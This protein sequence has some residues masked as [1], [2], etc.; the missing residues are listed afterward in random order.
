MVVSGKVSQLNNRNE[1]D[2]GNNIN[3]TWKLNTDEVY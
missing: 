3:S 2:D 1:T